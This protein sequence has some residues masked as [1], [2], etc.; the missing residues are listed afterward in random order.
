[1]HRALQP[2]LEQVR[3]PAFRIA[4]CIRDVF[5]GQ[6][7]LNMLMD[8]LENIA[9]QL[10]LRVALRRT[11]RTALHQITQQRIA[12]SFEHRQIIMLRRIQQQ[13]EHRADSSVLILQHSVVEHA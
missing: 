4:K 10:A 3:K 12:H 9:D 5:D 13:F 11:E 2:L 8:V 1:M 7:L 6:R